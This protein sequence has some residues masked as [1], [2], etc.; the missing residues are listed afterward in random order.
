MEQEYCVSRT[1]PPWLRKVASS[2]TRGMAALRAGLGR[3]RCWIGTCFFEGVVW[4]PRSWAEALSQRRFEVFR[5]RVV[6]MESE[7]FQLA[8]A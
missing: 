1:W 8:G 6:E 2:S 7:M 5:G 4:L 3:G